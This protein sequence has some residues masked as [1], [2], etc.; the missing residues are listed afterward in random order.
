MIQKNKCCV[1]CRIYNYD[2]MMLTTPMITIPSFFSW[3]L[4]ILG[5]II[6][7]KWEIDFRR[8]PERFFELTNQN[9]K[10]KNCTDKRC[11]KK[12]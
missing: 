12:L 5:L 6:L 3:S 10:C 2:H 11:K 9:L 4:I 1:T 7:V 8:H